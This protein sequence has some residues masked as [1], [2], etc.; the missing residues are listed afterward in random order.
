MRNE[1]AEVNWFVI[2]KDL[3]LSKIPVETDKLTLDMARVT[4]E[5]DFSPFP[6]LSEIRIKHCRFDSVKVIGLNSTSLDIDYSYFYD[7]KLENC[8]FLSIFAS[9]SDFVLCDLS[10]DSS[11]RLVKGY[12]LD[13]LHVSVA[14]KVYKRDYVT[15]LQIKPTSWIGYKTVNEFGEDYIVTFRIPEDSSTQKLNSNLYLCDFAEVLSIEKQDPDSLQTEYL[16]DV[17]ETGFAG[18][19]DTEYKVGKTYSGERLRLTKTR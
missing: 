8:K 10:S 2:Q 9:S 5:L 17:C 3:D 18:N 14:G 7:L 13:F 16:T 11:V 4:G 15:S 12:N 1:L 6:N 19:P